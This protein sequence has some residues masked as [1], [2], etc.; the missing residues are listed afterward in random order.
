MIPL[1]THSVKA[2]GIDS[3]V[4][5]FTMAVSLATIM[6]FGLAPAMRGSKADLNESLRDSGR[7]IRHE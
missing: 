2:I 5:G 6:I 3:S 1:N 7:G 4:L